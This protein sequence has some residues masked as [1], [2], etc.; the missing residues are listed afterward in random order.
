MASF[1]LLYGSIGTDYTYFVETLEKF[2]NF[3]ALK[4]NDPFEKY[5]ALYFQKE[6][7]EKAKINL[8]EETKTKI[9]S[10]QEKWK[11][12]TVIF[13]FYFK[14]QLNV[15]KKRN[16]VHCIKI[17][18]LTTTRFHCYQ[19]NNKK[20]TLEE[21][22][23][24][25][26]LVNF[27]SDIQ[28]FE[29]HECEF[30]VNSNSLEELQKD[31]KKK[32][33]LRSFLSGS[34]RISEETYYMKIATLV[35]EMS[36]CII[37]AEGAVLVKDGRVVSV[38][39]NGTPSGWPNCNKGGCD[40]CTEIMKKGSSDRMCMCIHAEKG[41]LLETRKE[42]KKDAELYST[43]MPCVFCAK[44]IQQSVFLKENWKII[45]FFAFL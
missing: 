35:R 27:Q 23:D 39:Y 44:D 8:L 13:P 19:K 16:Y 26:D 41:V 42:V 31:L 32:E 9:H 12:K 10:V 5:N 24:L 21:F 4:L 18:S 45:F 3:K 36:N 7:L 6:E 43:R 29:N 30:I 34:F 22:I 33:I 25:D 11:Q 1:I 28:K 37:H 17:T 15:F 40:A 2:Q 38:G 14:E 20:I